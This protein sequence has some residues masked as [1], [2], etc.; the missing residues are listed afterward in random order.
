M[1]DQVQEFNAYRSRM[2]ERILSQDNLVLK[3]LFNLD[4]NTYAEGALSVKTKELL[5]LVASMVLRCD[6]CIRYHLG[7]CHEEG[8]T[9]EELFETFAVANIVGG[10]IV[11]PH[12]RRAVEYWDQLQSA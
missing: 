5:G 7:R 2:N 3:R 11:I 6:D 9:T 8:V 4:T 10:T 1:K 12:L